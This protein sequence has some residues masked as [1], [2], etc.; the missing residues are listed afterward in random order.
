MLPI[1]ILSGGLA[2]R[3]HPMTEKIPKSLI[4]VAGEPFVFHQLKLL[5][6]RGVARVVLCVGYL[7]EEIEAKVGDGSQFGLKISYSFDGSSLLGTAGALKKAL[8]LLGNAFFVM[9]G[10]SYLDCNY[11]AVYKQY[12]QSNRPA[13]MTV[14]RN[15]SL[16][17]VSNIVVENKEIVYYNKKS[18]IPTMQY[19]DYG[20]GILQKHLLNNLEPGKFYDLADIYINLVARKELACFMV[21]K[22]FYE[23]GSPQGLKELSELLQKRVI[24]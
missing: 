20:L 10:D 13:L 17:D 16:Y 23:I 8:P 15:R 1:A 5:K 7:G 19:I 24:H 12:K 22:R 4:L 21:K 3:M 14:Y 2:T 9:Y 6:M 18:H 11:E